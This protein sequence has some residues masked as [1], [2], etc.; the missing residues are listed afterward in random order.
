MI[1]IKKMQMEEFTST[2][3]NVYI[4]DNGEDEVEVNKVLFVIEK[5]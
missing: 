5:K 1:K 2:F 3:D 4:N